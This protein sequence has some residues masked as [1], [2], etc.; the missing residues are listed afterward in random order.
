ML[1]SL[2]VGQNKLQIEPN[3]MLHIASTQVVVF[4][5]QKVVGL[6]PQK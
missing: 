2:H 4:K 6:N 1:V 3:F 5:T